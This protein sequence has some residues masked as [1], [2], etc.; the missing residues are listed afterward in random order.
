MTVYSKRTDPATLVQLVISANNELKKLYQRCHCH[1]L[2]LNT[3]KIYFMLFSGKNILNFPNLQITNRT[4]TKA[5][6]FKFL[7]VTYDESLTFKHHIDNITLKISRHI[8]LLYQIKAF[9][10]PDVLKSIYYAHIHSLLTYCN[11]IW[12]TTYPTYLTPL[13]LQLKKCQNYN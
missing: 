2:T 8:A 9:M 10:P 1:R 13:K 11:P 5:N 3:D 6:K 12:S 7:G 4:I